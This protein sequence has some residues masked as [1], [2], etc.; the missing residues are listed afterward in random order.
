[1][2]SRNSGFYQVLYT[3]AFVCT[4]SVPSKIASSIPEAFNFGRGSFCRPNAMRVPGKEI[5]NTINE[6]ES[7]M[8][9]TA[10]ILYNLDPRSYQNRSAEV[11]KTVLPPLSG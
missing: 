7:S 5:C 6:A 4:F 2:E 10:E 3:E 1:V 9:V 11:S 8:L